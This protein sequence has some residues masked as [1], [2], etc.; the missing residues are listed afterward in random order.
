MGK[1]LLTDIIV[2]GLPTAAYIDTGSQISTISQTL[3]TSLQLDVH[4]LDELLW[5][6]GANGHGIEYS[7]VA[8]V[9]LSSPQWNSNLRVPLIVMPNNEI[10]ERVPVLLGTNVLVELPV[11]SSSQSVWSEVKQLLHMPCDTA[12]LR[13]AVIVQP[14]ERRVVRASV[15]KG[16]ICS[17]VLVEETALHNLPGGLL[18]APCMS[19]VN[20]S[21][22]N[23]HVQNI[24]AKTIEI[25]AGRKLCDLFLVTVCEEAAVLS[26][27]HT[28]TDFLGMFST[29]FRELT[30][31]QRHIAKRLL[32]QNQDVFSMS[33]MDLG[34]TPLGKHNIKLTD[35]IPVKLPPR[36]IPP[37]MYTEVKGH[38]RKML[39]MGAIRPSHSSYSCPVVIAKKKDNSL[40]FCLD[41][42][43]LNSKTIRDAYHIPRVD[44]S[45]EALAGSSWFTSLDLRSG[46][47]Q[48]E[49][50]ETDK[51]KTAFNVGPLG[52]YE[53]NRMPFGL[54]NAP[55]TFQRIME[56]ALGDALMSFCVVYLDDI[57]VFSKTF[58]D[59]VQKL[60]RVFEKLRAANL[61]LKPSKCV[62]FKR[63][64]KYLGHIVSATG[65]SPDDD[66]ISVLK[67][68]PTP[69]DKDSLRSFL[70]FVGYY[71]RFCRNFAAI[72]RPLHRLLQEGS[73]SSWKWGKEEEKAFQTL[74]ECCVH[75]PVLAY[76]DFQRPF[77][78]H[79]DAS[80]DGLGAVLYQRSDKALRPIAFAS[81]S[82]SKAEKNYPAHKLEFLALKWSVTDKFHDYL[83]NTKFE[84][85][86]DN[87]PLTYVM[88][89]SRLD[90]T[91]Q[92]WVAALSSYDFTIQYRAGS[93]N[94]D[95]DA[96]SRIK[97]CEITPQLNMTIK[98]ETKGSELQDNQHWEIKQEADATLRVIRDCLRGD[99][100][101]LTGE[102]GVI[103]RKEKDLVLTDGILYL[104]EGEQQ[105]LVVPAAFRKEALRMAHDEFGHQ[106]KDKTLKCVRERFYWPRMTVQTKAYV[107]TCSTCRKAKARPEKAPLV[108][109]ESSQ[110]LELVCIDY[111]TLDPNSSK[112][113][114]VITDHF[115]RF[116]V[117]V[118]TRNQTAMV[119]AKALLDQF[120]L[121]YGI[122]ARIHSDRGRNFESRIIKGLC[123]MLGI[124]KS[125]TT[126]YHPMGNGS[127]ER[128]NQTL[129]GMLKKMSQSQKSKWHE[130]LKTVTHA[131]NSSWNSAIGYSPYYLMFGRHPRLPIDL[132]FGTEKAK[133]ETN[134]PIY[135]Q[136]MKKQLCRAYE[137]AKNRSDGIKGESKAR[138][139]SKA[140]GEGLQPSALVLVR[141]NVRTNKLDNYWED[142]L[143]EIIEQPNSSIPVYKVKGKTTGKL[144]TLHRNQLLPTSMIPETDE[145][146]P[147][148]CQEQDNND[149]RQTESLSETDCEGSNS[150]SVDEPSQPNQRPVRLRRRPSV[151]DP[152]KYA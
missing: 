105:R 88:T 24:T 135:V 112:S 49:L 127:V 121:P 40:R 103:M 8:H 7:G 98:A 44:E 86:T 27:D 134:Y 92:R 143:H 14:G 116:A 97:W 107:Y 71:R 104:K 59:H 54:T 142:E 125:R 62:F 75:A 32:V 89:S 152:S 128:F 93:L 100:K 145:L 6:K 61:K 15:D 58:E 113:V 21:G 140:R 109:I 95:A 120:I 115:S 99:R 47:W 131:Y 51:R 114:L 12:Y 139:D 5:V 16:Y 25:P 45:I 66:K 80:T 9:E 69:K 141:K 63:K 78:L 111:L 108:S 29:G 22:V 48:V 20:N 126:P 149:P 19:E 53:C 34:C 33:E 23:I 39:D 35:D 91:M 28:R 101:D 110:P 122:P 119:T 76:A 4:P 129:I 138:Y 118:P 18:M 132:V 60:S 2:N 46:Y 79:T 42:R 123:K 70:G 87:N 77:V 148:T 137:T 83:Y 11:Q 117:A 146:R 37:A 68:W 81:R 133:E 150:E 147:T 17:E 136:N 151:Y 85:F 94:K 13:Q 106:G 10:N 57:V 67:R 55:A 144:K 41:L 72:A 65:V 1:E 96:L 26:G 3:T 36:R 52:F 50:E 84:V 31:E 56:A 73:K 102:A 43:K 38:I 82:L 124:A 74:I 90:A 130:H 30:D 64:L